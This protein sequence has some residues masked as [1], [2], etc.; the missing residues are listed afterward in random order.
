VRA[1]D[2][3]LGLYSHRLGE[4]WLVGGASNC[5][6]AVLREHFSDAELTAL[7]E[8]IDPERDDLD[9]AYVPLRAGA[10]GERF[11]SPSVDAV[12]RLEPRPASRAEFLH[13]MLDALARVEARGYA[14]LV[15]RGANP[16]HTILS[17]GG[18]ASN[19]QFTRIRSRLLSVAARLADTTEASVGVALL[20]LSEGAIGAE[21]PVRA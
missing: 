10:R 13:A 4:R 12:Q 18:G 14:L 16:P 3:A 6:C 15:E 11:P 1:D 21:R 9:L 2:A 19:A 17:C 20:A 7:S 8:A 5:G